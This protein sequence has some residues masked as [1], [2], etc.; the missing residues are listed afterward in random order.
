M[1]MTP[2]GRGQRREGR[3]SVNSCARAAPRARDSGKTAERG[4][5]SQLDLCDPER[6]FGKSGGALV[7]LRTL[8]SC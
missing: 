1:L 4:A 5:S 6:E 3:G 7:M 2:W 8:G